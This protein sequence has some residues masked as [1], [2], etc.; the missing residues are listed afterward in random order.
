M[1][2]STQLSFTAYPSYALYAFLGTSVPTVGILS[3]FEVTSSSPTSVAAIY[4]STTFSTT[5]LV[6]AVSQ[7]INHQ[8][9][10]EVE[11]VGYTYAAIQ[12]IGIK[13]KSFYSNPGVSGTSDR[14]ITCGASSGALITGLTI[15][16]SSISVGNNFT[17]S[18]TIYGYK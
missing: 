10:I 11:N 9:V 12:Q 7:S 18:A 4:S 6:F 2:P 15:Q 13:C 16:Q 17:I 14:N 8:T 1:S 5:P 3:G